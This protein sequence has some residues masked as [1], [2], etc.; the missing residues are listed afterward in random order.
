MGS[1]HGL[2][3]QQWRVLQPLLPPKPS[4][5]WI[6]RRPQDFR[7]ILNSILW[8][9]ITG[10]RW[11]DLPKKTIFSKRSTAHFWLGR[12]QNDGTF[13][14]ILTRLRDQAYDFKMIELERLAADGFF[15]QR[16]RRRRSC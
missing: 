12:W 16:Q 13:Q 1:F 15:F 6:G 10:A 3:D 2:T 8:I 14:K 4:K 11:C 7:P 9:L 5:S